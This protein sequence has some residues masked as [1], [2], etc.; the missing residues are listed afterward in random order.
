MSERE[1]EECDKG[2]DKR[3]EEGRVEERKGGKYG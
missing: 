3:K 2:E 1:K